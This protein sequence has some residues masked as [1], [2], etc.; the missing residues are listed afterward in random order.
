MWGN[1]SLTAVVRTSVPI[2]RCFP[3]TVLVAFITQT[4]KP[5]RGFNLSPLYPNLK[6]DLSLVILEVSI[7]IEL[8]L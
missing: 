5:D 8:L 1:F 3:I 4:A 6:K 7:F 2:N